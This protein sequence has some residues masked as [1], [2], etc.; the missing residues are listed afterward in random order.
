MQ[1]TEALKCLGLSLPLTET[2]LKR[3]RNREIRN[4]HPD[5]H[6]HDPVMQR[7]GEEKSKLI[8]AA[9]ESLST[10]LKVCAPHGFK[11]ASYA[12]PKRGESRRQSKRGNAY[13]ES[14]SQ[15]PQFIRQQKIIAHAIGE[16]QL[17]EFIYKGSVRIVE[18]HLL[19]MHSPSDLRLWA[20]WVRGYSRSQHS[21]FWRQYLISGM[22]DLRE[23]DE[24][25]TG[26]RPGYE[27]SSFS[28]ICV[29]F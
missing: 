15:A 18:P 22:T 27:P 21:P 23:L 10:W 12:P 25:F 8:N 28:D 17:L 20:W 19:F 11:S 13:Y 7:T 26:P 29:Q 4:W 24:K 9:Y 1:Y 6:E 16:R 2:E 14:A 3:A 5:R